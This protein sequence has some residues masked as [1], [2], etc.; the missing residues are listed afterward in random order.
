MNIDN[1]LLQQFIQ[2]GISTACGG[3]LLMAT[4]EILT[5]GVFKAMSLLNINKF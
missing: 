4:Y 2:L 1:D 5:Y 3:I